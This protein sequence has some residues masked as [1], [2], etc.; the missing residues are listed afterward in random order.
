ME[1]YKF[2]RAANNS[3]TVLTSAPLN[4]DLFFKFWRQYCEILRMMVPEPD[5]CDRCTQLSNQL[6]T[7]LD[8]DTRVYLK[9]SSDVH[10]AET[11]AEFS[12]HTMMQHSAK[13]QPYC[14]TRHLIFDFAGKVLLPFLLRKPNQLHFVTVP[15]FELYG[16][17][18]SNL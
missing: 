9:C 7:D 5:Y 4:Q 1:Y 18:E 11:A 12:A 14:G 8:D 3:S 2:D 13:E 15:N 10:K 17:S 16:F 6:Q